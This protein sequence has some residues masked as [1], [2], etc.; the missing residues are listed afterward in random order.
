MTEPKIIAV[1]ELTSP[2]THAGVDYKK[3]ELIEP[4]YKHVKRMDNVKGDIAKTGE[5]IQAC[6]RLPEPVVDELSMVDLTAISEIL[7]PFLV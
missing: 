4:K 1:Y 6:G 3:I 7:M 2:I 5:I